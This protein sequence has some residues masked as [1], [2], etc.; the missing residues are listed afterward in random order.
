MKA[1]ISDIHFGDRHGCD[2]LRYPWVQEYLWPYLED[3]DE[4]ILLGDTFE[5][6]F[7]RVE[8]ALSAARPFF[9]ELNTRMP[10][11]TLR[12]LPGNHDHHLVARAAD[13]QREDAALGV[14][15]R[16]APFSVAP[17]ER[18]FS[19]LCPDMHIQTAY[20]L[21]IDDGICFTHGHYLSSH[22]DS[23][24]WKTFDR[25][26]WKLWGQ[27]RRHEGLDAADYEALI[28][29]IHE[30]WYQVAQ[31]PEGT[32]NQ[33]ELE[34][35]LM[36]VANLLRLPVQVTGQV[37]RLGQQVYA[38]VKERGPVIP[39][40]GAA[41]A[42]ESPAALRE[43]AP[44]EPL[45]GL[46]ALAQVIDNLKLGSEFSQVVFAHTHQPLES[47]RLEH[48]PHLFHNS[49]SWF[50]DYRVASDK[51]TESAVPGTILLIDE[52]EVRLHQVVPPEALESFTPELDK[53]H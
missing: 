20:P 41:L 48:N 14:L 39:F 50:Y 6:A 2:L 40:S 45:A 52:A 37:G 23:L 28:S 19:R 26:Q 29:P 24:G 34:K 35:R 47:A 16:A 13:E 49:G 11:C 53:G 33:Q 1:V 22:L 7:Q 30:L 38:K 46:Q 21:F 12:K 15:S 42:L 44:P 27:P 31:L 43:E 51:Q 10:G 18:I 8:T 25:L 9:N 36:R 4:L 5:F 32:R 17:A 3:C